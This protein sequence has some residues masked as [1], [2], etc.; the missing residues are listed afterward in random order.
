MQWEQP[1]DIESGPRRTGDPHTV[2]QADI[3]QRKVIRV[4]GQ[5]RR[6]V[7]IR[8]DDDCRRVWVKPLGAVHRGRRYPS[9]HRVGPGEQPRRLGFDLRGQV[10]AIR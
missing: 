3:L 1:A 7:A 5:P 10:N 9:Q 8:S 4:N 2:T 6:T